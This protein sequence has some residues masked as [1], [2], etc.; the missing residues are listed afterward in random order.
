[1]TEEPAPER[2]A[3]VWS[4]EARDDLR[5]VDRESAMQILYWLIDTSPTVPVRWKS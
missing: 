3:V 5:A 4:P 2:M 1:M